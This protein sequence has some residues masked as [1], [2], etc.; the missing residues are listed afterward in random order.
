M[1]GISIPSDDL[2]FQQKIVENI[3]GRAIFVIAV[4]NR[5]IFIYRIYDRKCSGLEYLLK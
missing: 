1:L 2:C 5:W 4:I 3:N